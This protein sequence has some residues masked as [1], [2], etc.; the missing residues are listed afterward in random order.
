MKKTISFFL[1]IFSVFCLS[2]AVIL[3]RTVTGSSTTISSTD[4]N[5]VIL[6]TGPAATYT[7]GTVSDGFSCTVANHGTGDITFSAPITTADGQTIT[8]LPFSSGSFTPGQSG[9]VITLIK[10]GGD[11][12]SI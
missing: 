5:Y 6:H 12:R 8:V 11:W 3:N 9:N 2:A 10:I 1:L 4:D 7:L